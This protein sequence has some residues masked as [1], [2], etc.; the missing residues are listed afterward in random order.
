MNCGK[1]GGEAWNNTEKV[2]GGWKGPLF[3][4]KDKSCGWLLWPPKDQKPNGNGAPQK[5]GAPKWT[6][7]QLSV[8]Y[9]RALI[10][11]NKHIPQII[12]GALPADVVAGAAVLFIAADRGGVSEPVKEEPAPAAQ[13][14][15]E[16]PKEFETPDET[17]LPF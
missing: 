16:K 15:H 5:T 8:T 10:I 7:S 6:W 3:K 9:R 12:K 1:C 4:C 14:L 11:A 17:D 2:N 13:P